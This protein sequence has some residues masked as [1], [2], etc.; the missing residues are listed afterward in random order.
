[1]T[2]FEE[3]ASEYFGANADV[4][5]ACRDAWEAATKAEREACA[6][7]CEDDGYEVGAAL[8]GDIRGR[9]NA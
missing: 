4:P 8:A 7:L 5:E 9:S 1:M 2:T 3:W 6:E